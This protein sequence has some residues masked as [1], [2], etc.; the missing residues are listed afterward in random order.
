MSEIRKTAEIAVNIFLMTIVCYLLFL[1]ADDV[2]KKQQCDAPRNLLFQEACFRELDDPS[3]VFQIILDRLNFHQEISPASKAKIAEVLKL[4]E[5]AIAQDELRIVEWTA[6]K[7]DVT[8]IISLGECDDL[9]KRLGLNCEPTV[10]IDNSDLKNPRKYYPSLVHELTHHLQLI[11]EQKKGKVLVCDDGDKCQFELEIMPVYL[12]SIIE[13]AFRNLEDK[14]TWTEMD[15][16]GG[17][18]LPNVAILLDQ[19]NLSPDQSGLFAIFEYMFLYN[20]SVESYRLIEL[21]L[22]KYQTTLSEEELKSYRQDLL[23]TEKDLQLLVELMEE[24]YATLN[25]EEKA[26]YQ[27]I[28]NDPNLVK[29]R[30]IL[31]NEEISGELERQNNISYAS[32]TPEDPALCLTLN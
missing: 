24:N 19:K 20:Q 22:S 1:L 5:Q 4:A 31:D 14:K 3:S 16:H 27:E 10:V 21:L 26:L 18:N 12:D 6:P 11:E 25:E 8:P 15:L 32:F 2:E 28:V 7:T 30:I 29:N 17:I 13:Y 9:K 23:S